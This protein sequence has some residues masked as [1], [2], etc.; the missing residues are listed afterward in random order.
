[1]NSLNQWLNQWLNSDVGVVVKLMAASALGAIAIKYGAVY[2][3]IPA[4]NTNALIAVLLPP[5]VL[6]V[7]LLGRSR[8][9]P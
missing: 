4:T 7:I 2:L 6:L 9:T 5:A 1:M 3:D 8:S